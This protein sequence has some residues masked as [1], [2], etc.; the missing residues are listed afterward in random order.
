MSQDCQAVHI[1]NSMSSDLCGNIER[2]LDEAEKRGADKMEEIVKARISEAVEKASIAGQRDMRER[3]A[4]ACEE[5]CISSSEC[6]ICR[7]AKTIRALPI[8][9]E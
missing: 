8:E 9:G 3:A 7:A 4:K 5:F 6:A 2:A 1:Y